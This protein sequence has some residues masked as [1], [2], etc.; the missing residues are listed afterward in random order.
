MF[1]FFVSILLS[2][3]IVLWAGE[4]SAGAKKVL[5]KAKSISGDSNYLYARGNV[6]MEYSKTI[7]LADFAKYDKVN[8]LLIVNG[9]VRIKNS[10]GSSVK[11]DKV[12]LHVPEKR[13]V[14]EKFLYRDS[15]ED[16]WIK[17]DTAER[18]RNCYKLKDAIFSSCLMDNPDWKLGFSEADYNTT[19]KYIKLKDIKF[20][21]GDV[22]VFYFPYLSFSTSKER[23]SGLL[24]PKLGYS[25]KE[26]F[27]Y[28]QP[29]FLAMSKSVDIELNPQVR[30]DR[31]LGLYGT[32]RFADSAYSTGSIRMG[33]FKDKDEYVSKYNLKNDEHYGLEGIYK[34]SRVF[35]KGEKN[36]YRDGVYANLVLFNDIDYLNLQKTP[37]EH[38][39][40]S[41]LKESR[42][43]YMLYN[44][45][46][47][48]GINA[49][50]FLDANRISNDETLQEVPSFNWHKF[51]TSLG[52]ESL[53]YSMDATLH[54]YSREKGSVSQQFEATLPIEYR[55][56]LL[57]GYLNLEL[58]EELYLYSGSYENN[59][60]K[61]NL[62]YISALHRIKI[63]SDMM[64]A[65]ENYTHTIQWSVEYAKQNYLGD[66]LSRYNS[67]AVDLRKDFLIKEPIDDRLTFALNQYWYSYSQG[68][69]A[70][71]RVSQ[72]YYPDR[73]NKWGD[74]RHELELYHNNWSLINLFEYSLEHK[75]FSEISNK[76][77]YD[78]DK[79]NMYMGLFWRKDLALNNILVKE[80]AFGAEYKQ[81]KEIKLFA[82]MT[83]DLYH[84]YS[85][86]WK[87]GLLYDRGCW[88]VELSYSHDTQPILEK[89]GGGSIENNTFLVKFNLA[90]FGGSEKK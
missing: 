53:T 20:Y 44:D 63:Y 82:N 40:D 28:E 18:I 80:L 31:S 35:T 27:I 60:S 16:I 10:D 61:S 50:Y 88:S 46:N 59:L 23:S 71:Q 37:M 25:S 30:T 84:K 83:Y 42:F 6:V 56:S 48:Y 2:F 79:L 55:H 64:K 22:P 15:S 47:Y 66:G 70:K 24:M 7:F 34:S 38:L 5:L 85:K 9:N 57:D 12:T 21:I 4:S 3:S 1:K 36:G 13:V 11:T 43:N 76:I 81:S 33:Y 19:S 90:S 89:N 62:D 65:Y 14:F 86:K 58:G 67:L 51:T 78:D 45:T 75:N 73:A 54:N 8:K 41:Y 17:S 39:S 72:I 49:K 69:N 87:S 52:S 29:I 74:L 68:L 77:K 26:G 32:L